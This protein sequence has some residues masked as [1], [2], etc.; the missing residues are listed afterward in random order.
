MTV[1]ATVLAFL[2]VLASWRLVSGQGGG[3]VVTPAA[4]TV[5]DTVWVER[6][7]AVPG[8]WQVRPG[9]L[10]PTE[11][12][13]P[14]ADPAVLRSPAGWVVRYA[15][16]AWQPGAQ[17]VTMPLIWRL[18]PNGR[19]DSLPGGVTSFTVASVI[20][21][22]L[23]TPDPRGPLAPLRIDHQDPVAPLA[24]VAVAT[25]LLA[26][27]LVVRRRPPRP[28]S[29][30]PALKVPVEREVPD[31]RWLAA[32]EP[33]AVA[34]RATSRLRSAVARAV[35]EAHPALATAECLAVVERSRPGGPAREL[36]ELLEQ[37]DRVAYASAQGTDVAAVAAMARRLAAQLAP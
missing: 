17:R 22:T 6:E 4:A 11:A 13:E 15:V 26:I 2:G 21:A 1:R 8:G 35:P 36:R 16:V 23:K 28:I 32:G 3:W 33:K 19:A 5:G 37:L 18:A 27:G 20:P 31:A 30:G 14:L 25:A 10:G 7:L 34:V 12:L 9:K 29:S 24:G